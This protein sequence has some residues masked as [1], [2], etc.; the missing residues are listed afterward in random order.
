MEEKKPYAVII[1]IQLIYTGLF[2]ISKAALNEGF[3]TFIFIFYRQLTAAV[4]LVPL[5]IISE[6]KRTYTMSFWLSVKIFIHALIGITFSL[7]IYN[8]GLKYTSATVASAVSNSV[9]VITFFLALLM[10]MES[11][12]LRKLSGIS[13]I[14]GVTIC[15]CGIITIALYTGPHLNPLIKFQPFGP[16]NNLSYSSPHSKENWIKGTFL[17]ITANSSWALWMV[18]QGRLL[19][20]YPSKLLFTAIESVFSAIQSFLVAVAFEREISKWKLRLDVG[21][22][23]IAY[24]GFVV[25]GVSF[26]M[27]SW[28]IE[29]KGPV[30]L[31][32]TTPLA[33]VFTI[34]CSSL[35]LG[36][37]ISLGSIFGGILMVGGLYSVLWGKSRE[38]IES[39]KSIEESTRDCTVD[40]DLESANDHV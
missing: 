4:L 34:I 21:L 35:F 28:C 8:V 19:K 36:E 17:L 31:A 22:I 1:I 6:R 2:V 40:K 27:Q 30:F 13:K 15:L 33:L 7:N 9:P 39:S 24:S 5:A 32:M 37:V 20:E 3:S 16:R 29:K 38:E 26:Y 25:T 12:R 23:A 14:I 18:L 11:L 10:R